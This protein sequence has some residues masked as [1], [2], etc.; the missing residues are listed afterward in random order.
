MPIQ[1]APGEDLAGCQDVIGLG[2]EPL[3]GSPQTLFGGNLRSP[4]QPFFRPL[5]D[6]ASPCRIVDRERMALDR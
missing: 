1:L 2:S 3:D 5:D 6:R 4:T